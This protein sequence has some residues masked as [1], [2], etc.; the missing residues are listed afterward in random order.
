MGPTQLRIFSKNFSRAWSW[1]VENLIRGS[2]SAPAGNA[3]GP[4]RFDEGGCPTMRRPLDR[5]LPLARDVTGVAL[6]RMVAHLLAWPNA[7]T[8]SHAASC[9]VL[10]NSAH[11]CIKARRFRKRSPRR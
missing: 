6:V 11:A 8:L 9:G 4:G 2:Q 5:R 1:S 3:Y 7:T 10:Q